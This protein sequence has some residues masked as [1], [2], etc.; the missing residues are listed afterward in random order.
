M[1]AASAD[2]SDE[3]VLLSSME[4]VVGQRLRGQ[5]T[6]QLVDLTFIIT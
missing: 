3:A 5:T 4:G 1:R 6:G 2:E